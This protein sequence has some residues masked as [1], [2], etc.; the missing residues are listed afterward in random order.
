[1]KAIDNLRTHMKLMR[2][3]GLTMVAMSTVNTH[4]DEIERELKEEYVALPK[5][6]DGNVWR[7]GDLVVGEVNPNNPKRVER[8]LWYGSDSGW[9]LET[10]SIL[11]PC[12]ERP[13]HYHAPAVEDVLRE[14]AKSIAE[15]LGGDEFLLR[16]DDEMYTEFAAKLRLVNDEE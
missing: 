13:R 3:Q 10:D 16:D 5:D 7:V 4:L 11:Y 2:D 9:Q 14:F 1:M 8:M 12:P 6:T 15:V